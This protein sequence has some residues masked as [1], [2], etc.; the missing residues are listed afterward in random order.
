M[1]EGRRGKGIVGVVSKVEGLM[2]LELGEAT[3]EALV[4]VVGSQ[5][6]EGM[7]GREGVS[8]ERKEL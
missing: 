5:L 7:M 4:E 3:M 8:S 6:V 2:K 1:E